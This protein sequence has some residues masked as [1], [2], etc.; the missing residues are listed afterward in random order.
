MKTACKTRHVALNRVNY[1]NNAT[2][3][4]FST[5]YMDGV[6]VCET[7]EEAKLTGRAGIKIFTY[8]WESLYVTQREEENC[9]LH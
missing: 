6:A 3:K 8:S 2:Q 1:F 7:I 9:K 5:A 4:P